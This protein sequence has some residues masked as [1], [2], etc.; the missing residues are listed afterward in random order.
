MM[1]FVA[2]NAKKNSNITR[3]ECKSDIVGMS[4]S[5]DFDSNITRLECKFAFSVLRENCK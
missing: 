1:K 5:Q 4:M 3:L 2:A